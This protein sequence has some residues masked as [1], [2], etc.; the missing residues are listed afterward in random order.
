MIKNDEQTT[1][2]LAHEKRKRLTLKISVG[3]ISG[4]LIFLWAFAAQNRLV[5]FAK[6][7]TSSAQMLNNVQKQWSD[8]EQIIDA[9]A[10]NQ[11]NAEEQVRQTLT[12]II[13]A[14][15]SSTKEGATVATTTTS[16]SQQ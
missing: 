8:A 9:G 15:A 13:I 6:T 7:D 12:N 2:P 10:T 11:T 5:N 16:T 3:I 14:A 1:D 4:I